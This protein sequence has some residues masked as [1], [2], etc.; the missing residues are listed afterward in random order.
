MVTPDGPAMS[1]GSDALSSGV[2]SQ[3]DGLSRRNRIQYDTPT[4][5]G[6]KAGVTHVQ[7]DALP[8]P[9]ASA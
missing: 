6:F 2:Y 1:G 7:G 4:I 3:F 9:R 5:A 8:N